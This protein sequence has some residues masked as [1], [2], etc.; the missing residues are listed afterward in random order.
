M[1]LRFIIVYFYDNI[2]IVGNTGLLSRIS[3]MA[4]Y[5]NLNSQDRTLQFLD[6]EFYFSNRLANAVA[7][8]ATGYAI[9][10]ASVGL[11]TRAEREALLGTTSRTGHSWDIEF[12]EALGLPIDT[13]YYESVGDQNAIAGAATAD[14]TR[15]LKRHYGFALEY[16][17]V[18]AYNDDKATYAQPIIKFDI[19]DA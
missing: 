19:A 8:T 16:A 13:Y 2:K 10:A 6:K 4:E 18:T 15:G 3:K 7:K 5:G 17:L 14:I 9:N 11:V 12:D 1:I